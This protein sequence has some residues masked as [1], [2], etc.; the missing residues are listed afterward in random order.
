VKD[1]DLDLDLLGSY[2]YLYSTESVSAYVYEALN[3]FKSDGSS[4]TLHK[5]ANTAVVV[6]V[7]VQKIKNR[8]RSR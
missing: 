1:T 7:V 3:M 4:K 8:K 5:Y 6:V 2:V